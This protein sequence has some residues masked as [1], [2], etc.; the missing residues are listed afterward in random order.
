MKK[1]F[2]FILS[3]ILLVGLNKSY[4]SNDSKTEASNVNISLP[5]DVSIHP[6]DV[7][8]L[9]QFQYH[10]IGYTL[11]V[12]YQN[13]GI[14]PSLSAAN[15]AG[16]AL[17][18]Q[19]FGFWYVDEYVPLNME[20]LYNYSTYPTFCIFI[21]ELPDSLSFA[22]IPFMEDVP[23]DAIALTLSGPASEFDMGINGQYFE[24]M[25]TPAVPAEWDYWWENG[26]HYRTN[27]NLIQIERWK[28]S[29]YDH[30][31]DI[32]TYFTSLWDFRTENEARQEALD[33]LLNNINTFWWWE[34]IAMEDP[35]EG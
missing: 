9:A 11:G 29:S 32:S 12:G 10:L 33:L 23:E 24:E 20:W 34:T 7:F 14:Y 15:T 22:G 19:G 2:L 8:E 16:D 4:A 35:I 3:L 30:I 26:W 27:G 31:D 28:Y 25:A 5:M 1:S 21:V 13:Q 18:D 6:E 17:C